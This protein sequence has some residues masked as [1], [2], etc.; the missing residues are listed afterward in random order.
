MR[1]WNWMV[2]LLM[3]ACVP[4]AW[5][6]VR[7]FPVYAVQVPQGVTLSVDV[8]FPS[9]DLCSAPSTCLGATVMGG[10]GRLGASATV[11]TSGLGAMANLSLVRPGHGP[12]GLILQGGVSTIGLS[13]GAVVVPFGTGFSV[14]VP[15]PVVSLEP[16]VGLRGQ[17]MSPGDGFEGPSAVHI[18]WSAGINLSLLNGLGV[19]AAYDR[20]YVTDNTLSTFG[21]GV[22]YSFDPGH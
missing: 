19:R 10:M 5:C 17:Y 20:V 18:A 15:T 16:W 6:Q 3:L 11:A 9:D 4:Q 12:F 22:Y 1:R 14:W 2:V 7:G 13:G 8:A 21:I